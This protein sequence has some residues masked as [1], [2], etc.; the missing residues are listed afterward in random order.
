MYGKKY[1]HP[2]IYHIVH[3]HACM[4]VHAKYIRSG[5]ISKKLQNISLS[6][7]LIFL[8]Q[9]IIN[10]III[11]FFITITMIFSIFFKDRNQYLPIHPS[12]YQPT[13]LS[14][15]KNP[16]KTKPQKRPKRDNEP[17]TRRVSSA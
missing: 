4:D 6:K 16:H 10:F 5:I 11:I 2:Y 14:R 17:H 1:T 8:T 7:I 13:H 15:H 3:V 12:I 9:I